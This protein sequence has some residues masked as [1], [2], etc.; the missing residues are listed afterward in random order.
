MRTVSDYIAQLRGLLPR[1]V[2]WGNGSNLN[3]LITAMADELVRVDSRAVALHDEADPKTTNELL[4]DWERLAGLPDNCTGML[5]ETVQQRRADLL[6]KLTQQGGQSPQY[7]ID[8]AEMLGYTVTIT[9]FRPFRVGISTVGQNLYGE[10]WIFSWRV[11]A[12]AVAPLTY[13]RTGQS[14]VGEPLVSVQANN[15]LECAISRA[16]PAHTNLIFAY[17]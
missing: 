9:E 17:S 3:N 12:S 13:F 2:A 6:S 14:T 10:D 8:L 7:F 15:V 4:S 11:N 16:S 1:G 5:A